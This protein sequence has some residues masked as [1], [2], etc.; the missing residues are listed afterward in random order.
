M[1]VIARK[2]GLIGAV[3]EIEWMRAERP[4]FDFLDFEEADRLIAAARAES[5]AFA[6]IFVALRTGMRIGELRALRWQDVDLVAG[7]I[8][9]RQ[10]LVDGHFGTPKS[11]RPREI[12][13]SNETI[14][15]LK[16]HRH[17]RGQYVFCDAGGLPYTKGELRHPLR[18]ACRK[19]GLRDVGWH[20]LR[21]TFASHLAMRGAPLK[22]VQE[23][24]GHST[25]QMTMRYAHLAPHVARE[26]VAL[27]D[28]K[29][30]PSPTWRGSSVAAETETRSKL[31]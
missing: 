23:L 24:L 4:D 11:G 30:G 25:I 14:A 21:H 26:A 15:V 12:A 16:S 19:A 3:P 8:T 6:T 22:A 9:V 1:L 28:R 29:D 13:L 31:L 2:R 7:R 17:L 10:N 5:E 18:R 20:D 27:L